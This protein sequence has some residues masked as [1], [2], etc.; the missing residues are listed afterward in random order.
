MEDLSVDGRVIP[1]LCLKD[2][3]WGGVDW[4]DLSEDWSVG[5]RLTFYVT[6]YAKYINRVFIYIYII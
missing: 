3:G 6:Q 1:K 5:G 4:I 2:I